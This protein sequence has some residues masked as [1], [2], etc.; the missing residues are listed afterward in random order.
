MATTKFNTP[1]VTTIEYAPAPTDFWAQLPPA[2]IPSSA[3]VLSAHPSVPSD[4]EATVPTPGTYHGKDAIPAGTFHGE[5]E[6]PPGT[7]HGEDEI[8]PGTFHG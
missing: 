1:F 2:V 4:L 3:L 8:P 6:I 5:D 7:F